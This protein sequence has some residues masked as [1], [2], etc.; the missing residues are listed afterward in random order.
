MMQFDKAPS[1]SASSLV[2]D[3]VSILTN[4]A[5]ENI[6]SILA[7]SRVTRAVSILVN[8]IIDKVSSTSVSSLVADTTSILTNDVIEN[9]D[10][11][12][13]SSLET[14]ALANSGF[15]DPVAVSF[16]THFIAIFF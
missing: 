1:T 10:S 11:I 16:F 7:F 15:F 8:D 12:F 9:I 2:P 4:N 3:K 14:D 5:L 13:G 6:D